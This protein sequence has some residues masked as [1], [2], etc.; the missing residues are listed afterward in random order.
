V[1]YSF[2]KSLSIINQPPNHILSRLSATILTVSI[3]QRAPFSATDHS[4][5]GIVL[6]MQEIDEIEDKISQEEE[7][8]KRLNTM[9]D[10]LYVQVE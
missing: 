3:T 8:K 6:N 1:G 4:A 5:K 2:L 7:K 9:R 10:G